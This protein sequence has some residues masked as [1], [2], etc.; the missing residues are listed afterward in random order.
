MA[1]TAS[2][3]APKPPTALRELIAQSQARH[4]DVKIGLTGLPVMENDEM[5]SSQTS[6]F[7]ASL[8]SMVA[9]GLLFVAGFGGARHA[10]LANAILLVGMA[11]AFGYATLAVGHLNILSVTFTVTLIGIGI[12]F[13]IYYVALYLQRR[14][15]NQ[16]CHT[17]LLGIG[18]H[19][20]TGDHHGRHHHGDRVF[21]G[22]ADQLQGRR[23]AGH[24]RRRR[25]P[26]LRHRPA[27]AAA[28]LHRPDRSQRLGRADAQA[29]GR[30]SLD[31]SAATRC[32]RFTLAV[33]L[34]ATAFLALGLSHLWY[35][36]NLL[37]MQAE[38]LE[39]V[40]LERKLLSECNQSVWYA[41]SMADSREELLARKEKFLQ[42]P[43]V[44]R[45]E[46]IVSL[47][48]VSDEVKQ[49][50]DRRD[51]P[52]TGRAARA[53]AGD[54]GRYARG[55]GPGAGSDSRPACR[56]ALRREERAAD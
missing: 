17:A 34:A 35:D 55:A 28:G 43:S 48:P 42:L 14:S 46:E 38:G 32:P 54:H 37:N 6:M 44:E 12:D 27:R 15:E 49:P 33:S 30:P 36:N 40:E 20:R 26:A 52:A 11:L 47:L 22:R 23:R 3:I 9:V 31:R 2:I 29:A 39:S 45:T 4:P 56:V 21:R 24:H 13:G 8:V 50:L 41:L 1:T 25:H 5:L 18:P 53:P 10:L 51:R 7:W 16:D 19:R